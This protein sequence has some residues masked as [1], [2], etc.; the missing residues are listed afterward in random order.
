MSIYNQVNNPVLRR[1]L[2][3]GQYTSIDYTRSQLELAIV[4]YIGW[5]NN[6]R[7]HESLGYLPPVEFEQRWHALQVA[8]ADN[9]DMQSAAPAAAS[10]SDGRTARRPIA[11]ELEIE[12]TDV[13]GSTNA[14]TS[15][16][17]AALDGYRCK[18]ATTVTKRTLE[19]N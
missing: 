8:N 3:P 6:Q 17:T 16:V 1:P 7:L 10:T 9:Q 14:P 13:D 18:G 11:L 2:E 15:L 4:E 19:T 5:F 12:Q